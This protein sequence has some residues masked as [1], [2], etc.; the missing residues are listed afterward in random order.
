MHNMFFNTVG[1]D[2]CFLMFWGHLRLNLEKN[3]VRITFFSFDG[4]RPDFSSV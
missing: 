2:K 3:Y 4:S 1:K